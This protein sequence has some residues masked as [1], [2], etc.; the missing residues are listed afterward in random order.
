MIDLIEVRRGGWVGGWVD[1]FTTQPTNQPDHKRG[2]GAL[3]TH[4]D[5]PPDVEALDAL[6]LAEVPQLHH[7]VRRA[8]GH[9]VPGCVGWF[10]GRVIIGV[11]WGGWVGGW[12][13]GGESP[14]V[15]EY[16]RP[17]STWCGVGW[18]VWWVVC[19]H[20]VGNIAHTH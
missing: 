1:D 13:M 3:S 6:E 20:Q 2:N 4:I 15:G 7:P 19:A 18:G 8:G 9:V 16:R 10:G 17:C 11:V 12:L 5:G 14:S